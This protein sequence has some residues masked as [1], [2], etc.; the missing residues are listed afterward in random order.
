[1]DAGTITNETSL[2]YSGSLVYVRKDGTFNM[3]GGKLSAV[4]PTKASSGA[5]PLWLA[6]GATANI[7]DALVLS[8]SR[9]ATNNGGTLTVLYTVIRHL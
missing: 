5:I 1:M 7:T 3:T 9:T 6:S 4:K 2:N 8:T